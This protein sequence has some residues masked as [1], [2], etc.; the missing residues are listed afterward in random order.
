M[1]YI[2][3][4]INSPVVSSPAEIILAANQRTTPSPPKNTRVTEELNPAWATAVFKADLKT[5]R[6]RPW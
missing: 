2:M 1:V 4:A 5:S 3:N 6:S